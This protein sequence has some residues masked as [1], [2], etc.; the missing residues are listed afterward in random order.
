MRIIVPLC[1]IGVHKSLP[2]YGNELVDTLTRT[3]A[4]IHHWHVDQ[5]AANQIE[6]RDLKIETIDLIQLVPIAPIFDKFHR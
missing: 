2:E 5:P 3:L 6:V 1:P 4:T